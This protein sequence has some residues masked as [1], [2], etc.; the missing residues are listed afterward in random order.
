[1]RVELTEMPGNDLALP[2]QK[3]GDGQTDQSDMETGHEI[4]LFLRH[5]ENRIG[6]FF[7]VQKTIDRASGI[8]RDTDNRQMMVSNLAGGPGEMIEERNFFAT[9]LAPGRPEV[10]Q[11]FRRPRML[12]E[13]KI[14]PVETFECYVPE[15][16]RRWLFHWGFKQ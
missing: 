11:C 12:R 8:K 4:A 15:V 1:M 9:R 5:D 13:E 16:S 10:D 3:K 6:Q 14:L 7:L 2:V